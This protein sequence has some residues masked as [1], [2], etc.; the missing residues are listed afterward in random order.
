MLAVLAEALRYRWALTDPG[1][2]LI[3]EASDE[4]LTVVLSAVREDERDGYPQRLEAF[5]EQH[6]K[7]LEELLRAY[8]PGKSASPK[9]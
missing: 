5:T 3:P 9:A 1:N 4:I 6:R 2:F 8:G 7:R